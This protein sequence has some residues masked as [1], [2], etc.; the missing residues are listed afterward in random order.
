MSGGIDDMTSW[1]R[2]VWDTLAVML[3]DGTDDCD[4][5]DNPMTID[6]DNSAERRPGRTDQPELRKDLMSA[7]LH[8]K[9]FD[10]FG[11][12]GMALEDVLQV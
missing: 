8:A 3:A 6:C 11:N 5:T 1:T 4:I 7:D 2:L 9:V 10:L 12:L